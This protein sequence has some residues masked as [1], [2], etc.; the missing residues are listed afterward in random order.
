MVKDH[1]VICGNNGVQHGR[2]ALTD[3]GDE[4]GADLDLLLFLL[5]REKLWDLSCELPSLGN[6]LF[7]SYRGCDTIISRF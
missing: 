7:R 6:V 1:C 4:L 2:R 5:V 3:G